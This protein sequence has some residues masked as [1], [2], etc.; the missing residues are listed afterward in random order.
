MSF[1]ISFDTP[2]ATQPAR[3]ARQQSDP[4]VVSAAKADHAAIFCFLKSIFKCL[5]RS[6]FA[7]SLDDPRY[8]PCDRLLI[9]SGDQIVA[10][11]HITHRIM[12]FGSLSIPVGGV[13]W[14]AVAPEYRG[15][16][17]GLML[18]EAAQRYMVSCGALVGLLRTR[19]PH[20]FRRAGWAMCGRQ[21]YSR[22][23]CRRILAKLLERKTLHRSRSL[24]IRPLRRW[25]IPALVRI[26]EQNLPGTY[27][28][29]QRSAEYWKWLVNRQAF[30]VLYV[31]LDGPDQDDVRVTADC[32]V[33]YA[34]LRGEQI[35]ELQ[36]APQRSQVAVEL[37]ARCCRD[38]MEHDRQCVLLHSPPQY[39]LHDIILQ[40]GG[41]HHYQA[42]DEHE[43]LMARLLDPLI[44]LRLLSGQLHARALAAGLP[45]AMALGFSVDGRHYR[46]CLS[47]DGCTAT[48]GNPGP[49]QLSLNI[50]DFTRM[51]LGELDW[52]CSIAE[53]RLQPSTML[54]EQIGRALMPSL[55]LWR[56]P[57]DDLLSLRTGD[58]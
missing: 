53:G 33:G 55:P 52:D 39:F 13:Q 28:P 21:N 10:H 56:P 41:V 2:P 6:E 58:A 5:T 26:Y 19:I 31:A 40:A 14:L 38:A 11:A 22:A 44:L 3:Q 4:V 36:T 27:G 12:Q 23:C 50:A 51:V 7:S 29:L 9:K 46:L 1:G 49:H 30:D 17:W 34:V 57:L 54:A 47:K 15:R 37:L 24:H 45:A 32:I 48:T 16:G 8:C 18:L 20:F 35:V 43:V 42:A 25:E